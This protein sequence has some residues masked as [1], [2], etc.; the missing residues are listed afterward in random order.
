[1]EELGGWPNKKK[2]RE[3]FIKKKKNLVFEVSI[4]IRKLKIT[5]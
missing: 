2:K 4:C 1:M 5:I 3:K